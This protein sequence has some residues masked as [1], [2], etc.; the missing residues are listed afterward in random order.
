VF[1]IEIAIEIGIGVGTEK[2]SD[3]DSDSDP[4]FDF[5]VR[6]SGKACLPPPG[7]PKPIFERANALP[8]QLTT[9]NQQPT[10]NN[11]Q[12]PTHRLTLAIGFDLPVFNKG[13]R[14]VGHIFHAAECFRQLHHSRG[15]P[16]QRPRKVGGFL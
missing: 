6:G 10:T 9:R 5:R 14:G 16:R 1:P 8:R 3:G 11:Q 7:I 12:L 13:P 2:D 4:D 15:V